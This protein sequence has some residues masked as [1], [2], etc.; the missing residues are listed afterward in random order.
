MI[1]EPPTR[2]TVVI[3][4]VLGSATLSG[5]S[6]ADLTRRHVEDPEAPDRARIAQA[7]ELSATLSAAI[8][9]ATASDPRTAHAFATFAA[10]HAQQIAEL[11]RAA[12]LPAPKPLRVVTASPSAPLT[13]ALLRRREETLAQAMRSLALGAQS[14]SVAALLASAAAGIDQ[15]LSR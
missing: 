5:C 13:E 3:G 14:G 11:S 10:L 7:R 9:A 8:E 1:A 2:R 4:G 15:A 6:L 12:R